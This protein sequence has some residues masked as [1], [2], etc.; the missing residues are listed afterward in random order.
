MTEKKRQ[1]NNTYISWDQW[2]SELCSGCGHRP[3]SP[4]CGELED[5][6]PHGAFAELWPC[7][8]ETNSKEPYTEPP[9][10]PPPKLLSGIL[11]L[12]KVTKPWTN[13][14]GCDFT[15][16]ICNREEGHDGE[17]SPHADCCGDRYPC[18][19]TTRYCDFCGRNEGWCTS[20]LED[21]EK[22]CAKKRI[23]ELERQVDTSKS[24]KA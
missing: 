21:H 23:K 20:C 15:S 11:C 2:Q 9:P 12:K 13:M 6:N 10:P 22:G 8:C 14:N 18:P 19:V 7:G 16:F 3:H 4:G 1:Y 5:G 17:C 24:A